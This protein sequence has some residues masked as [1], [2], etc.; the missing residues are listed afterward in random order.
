MHSNRLRDGEEFVLASIDATCISSKIPFAHSLRCLYLGAGD[1]GNGRFA[2]RERSRYRFIGES[3]VQYRSQRFV[4]VALRRIL[5]CLPVLEEFSLGTALKDLSLF[6]GLGRCSR[7]ERQGLWGEWHDFMAVV[8]S[9]ESMKDKGGEEETE[10]WLQNERP[11]L[12][13]L[14]IFSS[15]EVT[16]THKT[17]IA[18]WQ[19]SLEH[20]FR[21]LE[22]LKISPDQ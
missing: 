7:S 4:T 21:F 15:V 19:K 12:R 8:T 18:A 5:A 3:R 6:E 10:N 22:M 9:T 20:R 11:F 2:E 17:R 14:R 1:F 16:K 13:N